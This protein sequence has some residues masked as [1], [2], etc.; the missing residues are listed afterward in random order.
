MRTLAVSSVYQF[1][2]RHVQ[3]PLTVFASR[4]TDETRISRL[5]ISNHKNDQHELGIVIRVLMF[6]SDVLAVQVAHPTN[7]ELFTCNGTWIASCI[8]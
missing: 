4:R 2:N 1:D 7:A 5:P 8:D 6:P 3:S